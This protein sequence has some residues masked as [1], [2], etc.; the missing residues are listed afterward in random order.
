MDPT[1]HRPVEHVQSLIIWLRGLITS[2]TTGL[3]NV[4]AFSMRMT[5]KGIVW[6]VDVQV[7]GKSF[8]MTSAEHYT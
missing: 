3:L 8:A 4:I 2:S 1:Y 7:S 6:C 5:N